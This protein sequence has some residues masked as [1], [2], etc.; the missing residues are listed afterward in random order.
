MAL[1]EKIYKGDVGT[2]IK[3]RLDN[4]EDLSGGTYS[5]SVLKPDGTET[6]W[7]ASYELAGSEQYVKYTT[8]SG[9]LDQ[10]GTYKIQPKIVIPNWSGSA[11]TVTIKV[12]DEYQ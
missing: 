10:A 7:T 5:F 8:V 2:V 4:T 1:K 9:D 11:N 12:Y 3:V 6:T